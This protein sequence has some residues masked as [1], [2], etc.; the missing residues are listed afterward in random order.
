M[1]EIVGDAVDVPR[2][3]HRIDE[4]KDQHEPQRQEREK[5]EHPKEVGDME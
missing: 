4:P 3:A 1:N 5:E 2:N